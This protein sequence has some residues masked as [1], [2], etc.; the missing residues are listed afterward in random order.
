MIQVK[1]LEPGNTGIP[2]NWYMGANHMVKI[3]PKS[4]R[5]LCGMY[6]VPRVGYECTVAFK[7]DNLGFSQRLIVQNVSGEFWLACSNVAK[8]AWGETFGVSA[9]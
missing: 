9:V 3:G 4:A 8:S 6:P 5:G 1:A 2:G 7:K